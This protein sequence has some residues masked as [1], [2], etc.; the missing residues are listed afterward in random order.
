MDA[1]I[2][3]RS[4]RRRRVGTVLYAVVVGAVAGILLARTVQPVGLDLSIDTGAPIYLGFIVAVATMAV[5]AI[6]RALLDRWPVTAMI[7]PLIASAAG[8]WALHNTMGG[9][10]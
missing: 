1:P 7:I 9:P 2:E 3:H 4:R 6:P 5:D 10:T 8:W